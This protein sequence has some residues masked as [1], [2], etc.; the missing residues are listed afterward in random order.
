MPRPRSRVGAERVRTGTTPAGLSRGGPF[1]KISILVVDDD[2]MMREMVESV[3][4][5][6]ET[7][8]SGSQGLEWAVSGDFSCVVGDVQMR[9]LAGLEMLATLRR[10]KP[11]TP[12]IPMTSIGAIGVAVEAMRLGAHDFV[13]EPFQA[14]QL[15]LAIDRALETRALRDENDRLHAATE[16]A[17]SFGDLVGKSLAMKE[18]YA[19]NRKIALDGGKVPI[20]GE[21]GTCKDVVARTI[22]LSGVRAERPLVPTSC[23]AM[24]EGF[25]ESELFG[26]VRGASTGAHSDKKASSRV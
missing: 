21:R 25:L 15:L 4:H 26:H 11:E 7:A 2:P 23:T 14:E 20:S 10:T 17:G 9:E 22:H 12:V 6:V 18:I 5:V 16:C 19:L 1:V 3:G 8:E 24:P 13:T